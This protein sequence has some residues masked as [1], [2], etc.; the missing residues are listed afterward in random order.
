MS[1]LFKF[2]LGDVLR[3]NRAHGSSVYHVVDV[4][5]VNGEL[6]VTLHHYGDIERFTKGDCTLL[7]EYV[8]PV[9]IVNNWI[10]VRTEKKHRGL[11]YLDQLPT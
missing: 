1:Y 7:K 5:K 2:K 9:T 4:K 10:K 3:S 6:F 11:P 8:K